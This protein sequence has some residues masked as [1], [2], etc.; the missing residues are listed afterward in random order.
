MNLA[1][2]VKKIFLFSLNYRAEVFMKQRAS[3]ARL[4]KEKEG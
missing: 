1:Q 2:N 4:S 3:Y